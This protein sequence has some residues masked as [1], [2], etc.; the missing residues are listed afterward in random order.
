[1]WEITECIDIG[2]KTSCPRQ[3]DLLS[4]AMALIFQAGQMDAGDE[5]V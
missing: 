3:S 4:L 1:M 2:S 5:Q